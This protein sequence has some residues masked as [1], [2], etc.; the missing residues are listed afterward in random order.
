[1]SKKMAKTHKI[2]RDK[3]IVY[4]GVMK[5]KLAMFAGEAYLRDIIAKNMTNK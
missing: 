3:R 4:D 5:G 2:I 1:M